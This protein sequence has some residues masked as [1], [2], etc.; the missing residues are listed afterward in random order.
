MSILSWLIVG[1][2]A[3]WLA[4]SIMKG[5]GYGLIG[6]IAVVSWA[7]CWADSWQHS[8]SVATMSRA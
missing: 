4:G 3:G 2:I 7:L 6:D 8:C 1:L 5:R